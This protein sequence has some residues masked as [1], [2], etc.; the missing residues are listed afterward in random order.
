[1]QDMENTIMF[2]FCHGYVEEIYNLAVLER[3]IFYLSPQIAAVVGKFGKI[4][5]DMAT[6]Y[7]RCVILPVSIISRWWTCFQFEA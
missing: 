1:M 2:L 4:L 5:N 6:Q 7:S 3:D